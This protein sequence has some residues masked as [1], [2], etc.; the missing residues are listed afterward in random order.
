[1]STLIEDMWDRLSYEW[2]LRLRTWKKVNRCEDQ[3]QWDIIWSNNYQRIQHRK[4]VCTFRSFNMTLFKNLYLGRTI[5]MLSVSSDW[6]KKSWWNQYKEF[7]GK[8]GELSKCY[9]P[10][11]RD[12][13]MIWLPSCA[14]V[15]LLLRNSH[16]PV[17]EMSRVRH[18]FDV[19]KDWSMK[20]L[21]GGPYTKTGN[22]HSPKRTQSQVDRCLAVLHRTSTHPKVWGQGIVVRKY[23][24][25]PNFWGR[26]FPVPMTRTANTCTLR[27]R[28]IENSWP[29]APWYPPC[30]P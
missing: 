14:V 4:F 21:D 24:G 3:R 22:T 30:L 27:H 6:L 13:P 16:M 29:W 23:F 7:N 26:G 15:V 17:R 5:H 9:G 8:V 12:N 18:H 28:G 19:F 1:M 11:A 10:P 2:I 20:I 25:N